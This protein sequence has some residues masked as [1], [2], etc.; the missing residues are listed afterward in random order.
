MTEQEFL[1]HIANGDGT[2]DVLQQFLDLMRNVGA[3]YCVIGGLAVNAYVEPVV[4]LDLDIVV[5]ADTLDAL[6]SA[7]KEMF[8]IKQFPHSLNLKSPH[9]DLRIQLQT[10]PRYQ[11][12]IAHATT[13]KVLG[14]EMRVAALKDVLQGKVWA[15]LDTGRR[16]SKRH[17]D[18]ADIFRMVE[19][20]PHLEELLPESIRISE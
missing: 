2:V 5:A 6:S 15:Y 10:D 11:A 17:K 13:R 18:L 1:N 4:S 7:A 12:F 3:A 19:A 9:S 8:T 14:Y 16:R 20:H